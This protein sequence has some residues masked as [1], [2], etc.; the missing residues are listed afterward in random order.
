MQSPSATHSFICLPNKLKDESDLLLSIVVTPKKNSDHIRTC[1][2]LL[3]L[4][5][6]VLRERF[7]SPTF[8]QAVADIAATDTKIFEVLGM[9]NYS[10]IV[11]IV[12]ILLAIIDVVYFSLTSDNRN[13]QLSCN[14]RGNQRNICKFSM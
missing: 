9:G 10:I 4:N 2:E 1:I 7:Q 14:N 5:K 6:Y 3:H 13:Q 8:A 12:I 11:I